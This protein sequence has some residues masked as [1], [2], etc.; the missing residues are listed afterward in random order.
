MV[1]VGQSPDLNGAPESFGMHANRATMVALLSEVGFINIQIYGQA[2]SGYTSTWNNM[3]ATKS[4]KARAN[5]YRNEAEVNV[6]V[7]RRTVKTKSG[8]PIFQYFDG[9]TMQLFQLPSKRFETIFCKSDPRPKDC[10]EIRGYEP[11]TPNANISTFEVKASGVGENAGRGL[12]ATQDIPKG[13]YFAID[14]SRSVYIPPSTFRVI[15]EMEEEVDE[16][17]VVDYYMHGYGFQGHYHVSVSYS[18]HSH[19]C[20][21]SY[22]LFC[23]ETRRLRSMQ[24]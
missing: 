11:E 14:S 7:L 5:W 22:S 13:S 19:S 10:D 12:F 3:V 4:L 6:E 9:A 2:H 24:A 23:R 15:T 18:K 1:Q 21:P 8:S 17:T 16:L 20:I